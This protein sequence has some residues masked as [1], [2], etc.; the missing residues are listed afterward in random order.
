MLEELSSMDRI[1]QLQ[2]EI[3]NLLTIMAR[4][5]AYLT[6]R[7]DFAQVAPAIPVTKQRNSDKV[8]APAIFEANKRELVADLMRKANQL[9]YLI[10]VLPAPEPHAA[11]AA[12]LAALERDVQAANAEYAAA[13]ARARALHGQ[14]CAVLEGMLG[15]DEYAVEVPG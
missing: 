6:A 14:I 7:A 13:L 10:S 5:I 8:D 4:S 2:D 11:Q 3:Q 12:R 9:E 15:G 1:T